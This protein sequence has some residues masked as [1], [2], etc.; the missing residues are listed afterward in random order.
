MNPSQLITSDLE[1]NF[2]AALQ[3]GP[4]VPVRFDDQMVGDPRRI[5]EDAMQAAGRH[6]WGNYPSPLTVRTGDTIVKTAGNIIYTQPQ[7]FSPIHTPINWQIPSKRKEIYQWCR[8]YYENEPKVATAL[9]FYSRFPINNFNHVCPNRYVKRYFDKLASKLK[10]LKWLRVISHEVH[11][12][13]DCFPFLEVE[14]DRCGG[15]G[16]YDGRVCEHDGG[17]FK[18]LVV[19]NPEYVEVYSDPMSPDSLICFIP[20][21]ELRNLVMRRGPGSEKFAEDIRAR[22]ATGRPILLDNRNVSHLKYCDNGYNRYGVGM[23]RRLFP[24]L[25]YKTKLMTA[26]WIIAER[27]ILPIKVVKIGSDTRPASPQDLAQAQ[28]QLA[29]VA[30]DPNLCLVTHHNFDLDWFGAAGKTLQLTNEFEVINQEVLDGLAI[31]KALLNGEGPCFHPDVEILT[32]EGWKHYYE[33]ADGEKLATFN[34]QNG[35]M[36]FQ[37]FR[38]RIVKHYEG[39]LVQFRTNKVDMLT[40]TNHRMWLQERTSKDSE[41]AYSEWKVVAAEDVKYRSKMRACVDGWDGTLPEIYTDP[42]DLDSFTIT[43]G[44]AVIT[45][46]NAFAMFLGYYI[47]EGWSNINQAGISQKTSSAITAKIRDCLVATGIHFNEIP[48]KLAGTSDTDP[49]G[50]T[51]FNLLKDTALWLM[52]HVPGKARAKRIPKWVRNLPSEQLACLLEALID[53]DGSVHKN[54]SDDSPYSSYITTSKELADDVMEV[55]MK[56]GYAAWIS[57]VREDDETYVVN[58]PSSDIGRFPVLDTLIF[59]KTT[60]DRRKCISRVPYTGTVWCFEVPNEFLVVRKNGRPLIAGNTYSNAA[61]GVEV[62]IDKLET[63]RQE[64]SEWVEQKIYLPIAVMKGFVEKNEWGEKEYVYPKLKWDIMH[65]RDQQQYRTFMLQM[66]E[67]GLISSQRVL[68]AFDINYDEEVELLRYERAQGASTGAPGPGGGGLGGGFGGGAPAGWPPDLGSLAGGLG[69]GP[70]EG[71][72][73]GGAP[74][75]GPPGGAP[76]GMPPMGASSS[77][78]VNIAEFGGKVLSKRSREK[79]SRYKEKLLR[80]Q[81]KVDDSSGA[82]RDDKGRIMLTS[83]ERELLKGIVQSVRKGEIRYAVFPQFPVSY[84]GQEYTID[85]AMP[86]IKLGI[87]VDGSLFHSTEQQQQDDRQ[88]DAKLSQIG[89]TVLRF[90][91]R[92]VEARM[93]QVMDTILSYMIRKENWMADRKKTS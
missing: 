41:E 48:D 20:N 32:E 87:E 73:P 69:G 86:Q 16:L 71:G 24:I 17:E 7:F 91:D 56:L 6:G 63:W 8:Y 19:L 74:A 22:I 34:P 30:N 9:D 90:T 5:L 43:V 29:M 23:I 60:Q 80:R 13:G 79:I 36:E 88:R 26:Q 15:T 70:P 40:T 10:I 84:S 14:C 58:I 68:Q 54:S 42:S 25:A 67:K 46:L 61:I 37:G 31:N 76:G 47:S 66:H 89:W 3:G 93:R 92:E 81:E 21:E 38:N 64:I 50:M 12:L 77:A 28:S 55:A 39:D 45:N 18:R 78:V 85:F 11:L 49:N 83:N 72:A 57:Y 51:L 33:V 65:L 35:R 82:T 52:E 62:M 53:G 59:G 44:K 1:R 2:R 75:A 27:L 4:V